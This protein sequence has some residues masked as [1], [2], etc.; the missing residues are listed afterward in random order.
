MKNGTRKR[1]FVYSNDCS[2]LS[3]V[4]ELQMNREYRDPLVLFC[5]LGQGF[6]GCRGEKRRYAGHFCIGDLCLKS[7]EEKGEHK[8]VMKISLKELENSLRTFCIKALCTVIFKTVFHH[9]LEI[10]CF[11]ED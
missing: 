3:F 9:Y 7:K 11:T 4:L 2:S 10:C 1:S 6:L 8:M 5:G